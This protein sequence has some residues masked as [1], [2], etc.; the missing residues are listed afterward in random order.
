MQLCIYLFSVAD[1]KATQGHWSKQF[2]KLKMREWPWLRAMY[3]EGTDDRTG[4]QECECRGKK[5]GT[6]HVPQRLT[7]TTEEVDLGIRR[8]VNCHRLITIAMR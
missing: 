1:E 5:L 4:E 3:S 2:M 6:L 7:S 8:P